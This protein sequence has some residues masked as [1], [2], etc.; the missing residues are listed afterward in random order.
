[1]ST[2]SKNCGE[3]EDVEFDP[4]VEEDMVGEIWQNNNQKSNLQSKEVMTAM[5]SKK[6]IK[7]YEN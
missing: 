4:A 5:K 7:L 1:M 6:N 3:V 2:E